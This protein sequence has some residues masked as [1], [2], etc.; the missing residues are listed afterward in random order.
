MSELDSLK[1]DLGRLKE[2]N[3]Q[4]RE[5][6]RFLKL[7]LE[8][9]RQNFFKKNTVQS[10]EDQDK[11]QLPKKRGA[12]PGHPGQT[13]P[14]PDHCDAQVDVEL[15]QCPE[16][17]GHKL[18]ACRRHADHYQ[19]D[20]ILP[21]V[22]VT[23]FRHHFYWCPDCRKVVYGAGKGEL[24]G[25]YI[26]PVAKSLASFLH[27]QMKLPYR[28]I[29]ALFM[30]LFH[31]TFS[32]G[33]APGFDRQLRCRG[34]PLYVKMQ[35][36]LPAQRCVHVDETGWR[37]E[38]VNHWL[39]CFIA[40]GYALYRID[41][42]RGSQ[43]VTAVLGKRYNG[44]LISDFLAA[45]NRIICRKQ[46]CLVHLLRLIKKWRIYFAADRKRRKYFE[47]LR[48]LV[49]SILRLSAQFAIRP[50]KHFV[51]RKADLLARLRRAL[52]LRLAHPRADK[53]IRK[54]ASKRNQLVACL[55]FPQVCAHNNIAER[56]LR[57]NVIMRKI[58]F[59]NR[60]FHG[61][62]QRNHEVL[63]SLIQTARMQNLNPLAFLHQLLTNPVAAATALRPALASG[64]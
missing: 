37:N 49:K 18:S 57:D 45:Y 28:K 2:E 63:T 44:T 64:R 21:Q 47:S 58:T 60:S 39:W 16:C 19:E 53:F 23:R 59:G 48:S 4:L 32:P 8:E 36:G 52:Q 30:D 5:E 22:K 35:K 29:R 55:D 62:G 17:G 7:Q 38:G 27:Y 54:L 46:R 14:V 33:A 1:R 10:D 25:S 13:R 34:D 43:V 56:L 11:P 3:A 6:N 50:P 40:P 51:V 61:S 9:L 24:P 42:S 20:I 31:L 15:S 12:P 26:G 41:R